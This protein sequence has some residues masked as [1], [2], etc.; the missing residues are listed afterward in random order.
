MSRNGG[1]LDEH[2]RNRAGA[3]SMRLTG[4][5]SQE[6]FVFR[7]ELVHV[8]LARAILLAASAKATA[9]VPGA[10]SYPPL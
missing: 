5:G 2:V 1:R 3:E 10:G 6:K 7:A 4:F 8:R 9:D